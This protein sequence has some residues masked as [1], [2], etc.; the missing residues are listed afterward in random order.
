MEA[1][2]QLL[3]VTELKELLQ[4]A[5]LPVSGNKADLIK[6]LLENPEATKSLQS[7]VCP[8]LTCPANRLLQ[9]RPRRPR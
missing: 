7:Y 8:F 6:R 1:K 2:L 9:R 3:K 4:A 5:E